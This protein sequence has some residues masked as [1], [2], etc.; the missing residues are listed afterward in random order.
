MFNLQA[1]SL[2]YNLLTGTIPHCIGN[3]SNE[4]LGLHLSSN[5]V[6]GHI[7]ESLGQ[8][9]KLT[10]FD[11]NQNHLSGTVPRSMC[12]LVALVDLG[13]VQ[14]SLSGT[15]PDCWEK[16]VHVM[17]FYID[18]S[19]LVY[20]TV[21]TSIRYMVSLQNLYLHSNSMSGTIPDIFRNLAQLQ[22]L[23]VY[24]NLFSG[25]IP[26]SVSH[27]VDLQKI[28]VNNNQL[29]G[30]MNE[31]FNTT[32]QKSLNTIQVNDNQLTGTLPELLFGLD[33]LIVLVAGS[34]CF[35]GIL[36]ANAL[37]NTTQ[38]HRLATLVLDG[39]SS[40]TS[41]RN[42]LLP[43]ISNSYVYH[44]AF[45]GKVPACL[46]QMPNLSTLH[47]SGNGFTGSLPSD[48]VLSSTLVDL[49]L[50]H[51]ALS[52]PIPTQFQQRKWYNLDLSYNRLS[53]T[54]ETSFSTLVAQPALQLSAGNM[55][56]SLDNN[57][58]S[59]TV[60][61]SVVDLK[62]IS[63]LNSNVFSCR[64]DGSDLPQH[65]KDIGNYQ[66]GSS[67][68]DVP[69]Y[70]WLALSVS[71]MLLAVVA[72][73]FNTA[74]D[75]YVEV[76]AFTAALVKFMHHSNSS[77]ALKANFSYFNQLLH[78]LAVIAGK[79]CLCIVAV[80]MPAFGIL[81]VYY[82]THT[83]QYAYVV[84][85][86]F[87]AGPVPFCFE[88]VLWISLLLLTFW[89]LSNLIQFKDDLDKASPINTS[90]AHVRMTTFQ[91]FSIYAA[92]VCI[93]LIVVLAVNVGFVYVS[94]YQSSD[95]LVLAQV[96]LSFFKVVWN[97]QCVVPILRQITKLVSQPMA[98]S[99]HFETAFASLQIFV[100][101][102]NNIV[103]P[104]FVVLSISPSCFYNVYVAAPALTSNFY[105]EN[106]IVFSFGECVAYDTVESSST[107]N[108]PFAYSYQCSSD[109]VTHYAP[110]FV[111]VCIISTF[112]V[113]LW[114]LFGMLSYKH[115]VPDTNWF[116]F[117]QNFFPYIV[118]PLRS[119]LDRQSLDAESINIETRFYANR[120]LR[121]LITDLALL[122]TFGAVFPPL[123]IAFTMTIL[124]LVLRAKL[125]LGRFISTAEETNN[126]Q[127]IDVIEAECLG[128]GSTGALRNVTW[129]LLTIS[130]CFYTLFLFD[131]LGD[132]FG[133]EGAFWILIVMPVMPLCIFVTQRTCIKLQ[134]CSTALT[135]QNVWRGES[136]VELDRVC[137]NAN[138][139]KIS[140][141]TT[142]ILIQ[143][144]K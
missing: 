43:G 138:N 117:L 88:F 75:Q 4:L 30:T 76:G 2:D 62:T 94:V 113:P 28:I 87:L 103:I 15:L 129:T 86:S 134:M 68:F 130:C 133:F 9:T 35:H 56:I 53:G 144:G 106:C 12:N 37:C 27:L 105:Y 39:L 49:S 98:I 101:I 96:L 46:F 42:T 1:V 6:S 67:A 112:F 59:G 83:H 65:D 132:S 108:P 114:N 44:H 89:S 66:C 22:I 93:N 127:Y 137:N 118:R 55:T 63:I 5:G 32:L 73:R 61:H 29:T 60:P 128:V 74:I 26:P 141:T 36:P 72:W 11:F 100:S 126:V 19:P 115:A 116:F 79:S 17:N 41:C 104:Y 95:Y 71:C 45:N 135:P 111:Y 143:S 120:V 121:L 13:L 20:G 33:S 70:A 85:A 24:G 81:S 142:N 23:D 139:T 78:S 122:L 124:M 14:N 109:L 99:K 40:A 77:V 131:S 54:L 82:G 3:L 140:E 97:N 69:A 47:L 125:E 80:V 64:L 102:V 136:E 25:S 58:I 92:Y 110:A 50:S 51:N 31:V 48:V 38:L 57:R 90:R 18:S 91:K 10:D 52:G 7:P 84:S 34:N 107:Y 21:P 16:L 123:A 119:D 8:L